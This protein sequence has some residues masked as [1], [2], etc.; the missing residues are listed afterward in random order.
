MV[1]KTRIGTDRRIFFPWD[2]RGGVRRFLQMG[3]FLPLLGLVGFVFLGSF[4][5]ARERYRAGVRR[6]C[7]S[8]D[9]V[10]PAVHR[11]LL[12]NNG[13]CPSNLEDVAQF[14]ARP[15]LPRD[16]WGRPLRLVCPTVNENVPFVLMSDGPDG[17]AGGL[18]RIEY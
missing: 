6:T 10:R 9:L 7:V 14:L 3:R 15:E 2:G 16:G 18:D 8:L 17:L 4:V 5:V 12:E 1:F 11:Y 13:A